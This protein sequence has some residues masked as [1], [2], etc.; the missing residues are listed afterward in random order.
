MKLAYKIGNYWTLEP[1]PLINIASNTDEGS[2]KEDFRIDQYGK[3][4]YVYY[5]AKNNSKL[6]LA[7]GQG[8]GGFTSGGGKVQSPAG[9]FLLDAS[10]AGPATFAF[11]SKYNGGKGTPDG[12]LEFQFQ[13]AGINFK[14]TSMDWLVIS[15]EPRSIFRGTGT[16]NGNDVCKF[17][18]N[19]WDQ[20]FQPGGVDAFGLKIVSCQ[21]GRDWYNLPAT[22]IT[23]G[24]ISIR[25]K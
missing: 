21:A 25:R 3:L 18:V 13:A 5:D 10:T 15:G 16:I 24:Q 7:S 12:N 4:Y 23:N 19:A 2:Q 17:E 22:P 9:V 8:A 20:S 14:S 6:T 11:V 1:Q